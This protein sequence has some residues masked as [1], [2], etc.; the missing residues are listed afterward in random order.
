MSQKRQLGTGDFSDADIVIRSLGLR[1]PAN[2]RIEPHRH[3][4]HQLVYATEGVMRVDTLS[5]SWVVPPDRAV[6][7]PAGLEHSIQ[8]S[9]YVRM[10]TVYL[11]PDLAE[12]LRRSCGVI[13]VTPLLRELVLEVLQKGMLVETVPEHKRLAAVLVDQVLHTREVPAQIKLPADKRAFAVAIKAQSDLTRAMPLD[14][15]VRG[16]GASV[17]TI[18]RLFLQETGLTFGRWLQRVRALHAVGRLAEGC[19]VADAGLTVGYDSTSAFIAMFKRVL[20]KTPGS[21][22]RDGAS[23]QRN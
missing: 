21:Y 6:W 3:D 7:I 13:Q 4:W 23:E 11:R 17:R 20:G 10:Q 1:L 14:E 12:G 2:Q 19:S 9:G 8:M 5:A 22:A 15:L 16:C 18:E